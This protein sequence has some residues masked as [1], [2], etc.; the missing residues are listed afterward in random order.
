MHFISVTT[1][2]CNN[3]LNFCNKHYFCNTQKVT[4]IF[5]LIVTFL[6]PG[7]VLLHKRKDLA[8]S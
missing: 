2:K 3:T 6:R 4:N 1:Q 5:A 8:G 7:Y